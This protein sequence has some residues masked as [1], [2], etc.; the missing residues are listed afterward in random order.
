MPLPRE[1]REEMELKRVEEHRQATRDA[2]WANVRAGVT[3]VGWSVAG[4][5]VLGF[6]LPTTD[7]DLGQVFWRGGMVLGYSGILFT[8]VRWHL[9]RRERGDAE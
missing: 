5:A 7:H 8:V 1:I 3:C 9:K 2:F 4:L 6:G